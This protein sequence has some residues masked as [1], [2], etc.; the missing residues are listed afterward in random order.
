MADERSKGSDTYPN[1]SDDADRTAVLKNR[2]GIE[3]DR[4][5]A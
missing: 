3:T 4:S 1:T 5:C 2:W